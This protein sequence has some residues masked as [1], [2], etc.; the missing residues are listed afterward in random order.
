MIS[1]ASGAYETAFERGK[2]ILD[3]VSS[4]GGVGVFKR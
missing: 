1:D 2:G 3:G 4:V